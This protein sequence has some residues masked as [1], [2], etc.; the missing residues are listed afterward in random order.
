MA[1]IFFTKESLPVDNFKNLN[2][3]HFFHSQKYGRS[4]IPDIRNVLQSFRV[5]QES[6]SKLLNDTYSENHFQ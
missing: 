1:A 5:F 4:F 6:S 2:S 3:R